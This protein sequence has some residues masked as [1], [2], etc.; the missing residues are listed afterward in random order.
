MSEGS[1]G[2]PWSKSPLHGMSSGIGFYSEGLSG[3]FNQIL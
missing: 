2:T 3:L 1:G